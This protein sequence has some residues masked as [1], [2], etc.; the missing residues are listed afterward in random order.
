MEYGRRFYPFLIVSREFLPI[1]GPSARLHA[2]VKT[3]LN[4][5]D[6]HQQRTG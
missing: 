3:V 4:R 1:L 5:E 6:L 2:S